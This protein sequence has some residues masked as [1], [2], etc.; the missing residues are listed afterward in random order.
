MEQQ[1]PAYDGLDELSEPGGVFPC[2]CGEEPGFGQGIPGK[3]GKDRSRHP[4]SLDLGSGCSDPAPIM[5]FGT[6]MEVTGRL[7]R[8]PFIRLRDFF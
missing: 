7:R 3:I 5:G 8:E 2:E 6:G 4:N 1:D